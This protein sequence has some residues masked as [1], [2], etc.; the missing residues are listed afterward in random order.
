MQEIEFST[1]APLFNVLTSFPFNL[2]DVATETLR[3]ESA[4]DRAKLDL[5]LLTGGVV[6]DVGTKD[7]LHKVVDFVLRQDIVR[8]LEENLLRF[9]ANQKGQSLVK[10]L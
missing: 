8:R 7:G 5:T 3:A 9:G 1:V 6:N 2:G 4:A 10:N